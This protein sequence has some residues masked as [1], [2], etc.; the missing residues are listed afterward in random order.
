MVMVSVRNEVSRTPAQEQHDNGRK[1]RQ[2]ALPEHIGY[3]DGGCELAPSCL[4]CPL[5]VC[6]YD[7][8]GGARRLLETARNGTLLRFYEEGSSIDALAAQYRL[9]RRSV[10]RILAK[11][12]CGQPRGM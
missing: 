9:T 6:R 1:I 7:Q 2:D 8:K 12:R 5:E 11:E 3:D 10:F 4:R